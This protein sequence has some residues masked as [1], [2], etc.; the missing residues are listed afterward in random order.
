[1]NDHASNHDSLQSILKD[2]AQRDT[3]AFSQEL[4]D[5][6]MAQV[7]NASSAHA[8]PDAPASNFR[9][10]PILLL[11]AAA[12]LVALTIWE[13]QR[14][15]TEAPTTT[16]TP[17]P[18]LPTIDVETSVATAQDSLEQ[19]RYAY[20]D[21]DAQSLAAYVMGQFDVSPAKP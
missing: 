1:M 6:I 13:L 7:H 4:H 10:R 19:S 14:L 9:I 15:N 16:A 21:H 5:R 8:I 20:L 11:A 3:P 12:L 2:Q 17:I 18:A